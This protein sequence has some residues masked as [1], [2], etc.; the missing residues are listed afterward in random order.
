MNCEFCALFFGPD[1][2]LP[3]EDCPI[4]NCCA[5]G[6]P[7]YNFKRDR[8]AEKHDAVLHQIER[9]AGERGFEIEYYRAKGDPSW[10]A[11]V[12]RKV[13]AVLPLPMPIKEE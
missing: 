5:K 2:G 6:E 10:R 13:F 3:H 11:K 4:Y 7:L 9:A 8:T 12:I 1:G